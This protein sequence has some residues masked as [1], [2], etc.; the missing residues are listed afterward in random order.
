MM[1][2]R[3]SPSTS[4]T[5]ERSGRRSL[6]AP[7]S[8]EMMRELQAGDQVWLSGNLFTARDAVHQ[9]L[10][11]G[12]LPPVDL[13]EA[14]IYHCGPVVVKTGEGSWQVTAAGPTTS[15]REEPYMAQLIERFSLR[16]IIGKGGM[17]RQT[18]EA[19]RMVGCVY[20][21][22]VGGAAR[23]L[24]KTVR[25]VGTPRWTEAGLPE[26][27]WPLTVENFPAIVTI[28]CH[29]RNLHELVKKRSQVKLR[30][31]LQSAPA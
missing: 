10:A 20:L 21:Q 16:L 25:Q 1:H 11:A 31:L 8:E 2:I 28:D 3:S 19:C 15:N 29:G 6:K 18:M 17:G 12:E 22:A 4:A 5:A 13:H 23:V 30:Q 9:R 7:F 24:A 27:I 26:A 14:V